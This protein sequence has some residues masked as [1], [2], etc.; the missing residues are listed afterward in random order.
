FEP[1]VTINPGFPSRDI[2]LVTTGGGPVLASVDAR[3]DAVS[4]YAWRNGGFV[5]V[6]SL[7]T[8][9]LPA[10]IVS[11]DLLGDGGG[12][13]V[14]RNA[15]D[16]TLTVIPEGVVTH[17]QGSF[18]VTTLQVG[19]GV[20]DIALVDTT[21]RGM[22]D[23]AVTNELAGLVSVIRNLGG[24]AFAPPV[25]YR[26]GT[27]LLLADGSD[28]VASLEATAGVV[29]GTFTPSGPTDLLTANPGS[30]T[31][32]LLA[33]LG[34]GR[35]ANPEDIQ[36][37]EP[38]QVVRVA[39]F[40]HDG[41]SDIA[42]LEKDTVSIYLGNGQ[43]GFSAPVV[44]N[45]GLDPTGLT[46][47]D[48]GH[49]GDLDLLIG[50]EY[51]DVLVLAGQGNGTFRPLLDVGNSVALAV[52]DLTGNGI[53]D[54]I[55]ASQNLDNVVV[56]Y[57]GGQRIS[58]GASSGLLAP[59]AVAVAYLNGR[60]NPPDLIVANSGGNN[61]LVYPGLGNGQFGPALNGGKGFFTGTDPVGVTVANLNGRLD[62]VI[63]DRG[64]NDVTILLNQATADG[65]FTFVP[66]P[67]LNL[68]TATQQ[69]IGPVATAIVPSPTG[70]PAS[71][72]VSVSGSNQVWVIPSVGGGFFNDQNPTIFDVGSNPGP[73]LVGNFDGKPDLVAVNAGSNSLTLIS[74]FTGSHPVTTTISSGGL[75]PVA[76]FE[77]SSGSGFDNLVVANNGDGTFALL[78]GGPDG[79]NLTSTETEPGL[80]P[81][82][83]AFLAFTGGQVQFYAATEGSETATLL[84]FQLGL[85][86]L[87]DAALPLIATLL[88]LTIETSTAELN[89]GAFEGEAAAAV[90]FLP[91]ST[92]T[93][94]QSLPVHAGTGECENSDLEEP[95]KPQEPDLP[96]TQE[97]S[98]WQPF[99]MGLDE[100][101]DQFCRDSLD[102]FMSRDEPAPDKTQ[103]PHALSQPLNLWQR[104]QASP[105]ARGTIGTDSNHLPQANQ[106][107]IIDEAI[108]SL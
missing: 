67:R 82:D 90:S 78:E 7:P 64:S 4:L 50:N 87:R 2:A 76:A 31:L 37:A 5:R 55:Y 38:A 86:P 73:I 72:A 26:A 71:L 29:G 24:G 1:P 88:T 3:D 84:T 39:D 70:G 42:V 56:D 94:G 36:T 52:A 54:I 41:I 100:A 101:L 105:E 74:D 10:Q 45:A 66:G 61:V 9:S 62:L 53:K 14:V 75:D 92:V 98:S 108:R 16:G 51:G 89:P 22:L 79:L 69:G 15:G 21:G 97:S 33:G 59:G 25:P 58:V 65:G 34:A 80:N 103:P 47:A 57:G 77:F 13:L 63:A 60:E 35:F 49:D 81:T 30:N 18:P 32:G 19:M 83:L 8:G 96:V 28:N 106:G 6:G 20:S 104:D 85:Q 46:V 95:N 91:V 43:G 12:D 17:I 27:G 99:L 40:N 23:I 93:V 68:K 44:Y 102:Q 107:Q 48:L 11:G